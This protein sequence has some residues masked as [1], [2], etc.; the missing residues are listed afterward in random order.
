MAGRCV[1]ER[2]NSMP[3]YGVVTVTHLESPSDFNSCSHVVSSEL[4][5]NLIFKCLTCAWYQ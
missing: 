4:T 1:S 3:P 2:T 5:L